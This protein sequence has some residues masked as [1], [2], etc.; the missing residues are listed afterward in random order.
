MLEMLRAKPQGQWLELMVKYLVEA[1]QSGSVLQL[2]MS[3]ETIE[4]L[5]Q[6]LEPERLAEHVASDGDFLAGM[7][8]EAAGARGIE[9]VEVERWVQ[10]LIAAFEYFFAADEHNRSR[11][12]ALL[13]IL[14]QAW[15]ERF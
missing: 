2:I 14:A 10:G 8:R 5:L 13:E 3:K 12:L 4:W 7:V 15:K 6:K 11:A 1:R 9:A